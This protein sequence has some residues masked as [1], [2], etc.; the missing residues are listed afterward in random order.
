M[1]PRAVLWD[2]D[3]TL[4]DSGDLHWVAWRDAMAAEGV[5]ITP[6][7]FEA[8]FGWKND[9]ILRRWLGDETSEARKRQV[10]DGKE[11][12]YRT[13]LRQRG[14]APLPGAREWVGRLHAD[15]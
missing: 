1:T 13:A 2:L 12:A 6:E 9:P 3:G 8:T 7:M 5:A 4:V 11:R 15:G 10:A 14:L